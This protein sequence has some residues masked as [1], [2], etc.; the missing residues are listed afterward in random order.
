LSGAPYKSASGQVFTTGD[1]PFFKKFNDFSHWKCYK[2][3]EKCPS[4]FAN[5][6]G[7]TGLSGDLGGRVADSEDDEILFTLLPERQN[8]AS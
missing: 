5:T 7:G 3:P 8:I 2:T 6:L 1:Q 4:S